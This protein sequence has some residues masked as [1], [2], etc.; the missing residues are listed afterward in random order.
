MASRGH[1][2]VIATEDLP[3]TAAAPSPPS[4]PSAAP[5]T[6][7]LHPQ[8]VP[9]TQI[10][11]LLLK[12]LSQRAVDLAGHLLPVLALAV[13]GAL[14]FHVIESPTQLQLGLLGVFG[15]FVLALLWLVR[16]K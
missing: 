5:P 9:G 6:G 2:Q 11:L 16:R 4:A 8:A 12:V 14:A 10:L 13:V 1:F 3:E 15:T 7:S